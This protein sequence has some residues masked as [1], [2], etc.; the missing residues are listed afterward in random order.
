MSTGGYAPPPAIKRETE[1]GKVTDGGVNNGIR[2]P[3]M[4]EKLVKLFQEIKIYV[5]DL[6]QKYCIK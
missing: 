4:G 2:I 3:N 6:C 1:Q 5:N